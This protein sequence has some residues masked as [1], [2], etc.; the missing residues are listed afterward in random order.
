MVVDVTEKTAEDVLAKEIPTALPTSLSG[1]QGILQL[2]HL[3]R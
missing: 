1:D 3:Q 2:E